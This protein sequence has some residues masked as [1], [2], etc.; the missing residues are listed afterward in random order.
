MKDISLK[1]LLEAGCHF[2][3]K[4]SRWHPKASVFIYQA[5]EGIHIIDLAKTRDGL[6]NAAQ[7]VKNL[8]EEGKVL[9]M[10][11]TKRQ[12]KA[13]VTEAAKNKGINYLTAR[14]IGGF[15]TNWEEVKKNIDKVN[16][17]RKEKEDG[18]WKKF[19]KHEQIA[20]EKTLKKLESVYTGVADLV[21]TPDAIFMVDIKN[22]INCLREA[23]RKNIPVIAI[24]D[25]NADPGKADLAIPANDDAVGS[26]K[27]I[28]EYIAEAYA[29]GKEIRKK[30]EGQTGI[31]NQESGVKNKE[32]EK[33]EAEI[34]K[35]PEVKEEVKKPAAAKASADDGEKK[36]EEKK[37]EKKTEKKPVQKPKV[38]KEKAK[39]K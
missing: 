27:I 6:K 17:M 29:E 4:V 19:V 5:R 7:Y 1:D 24:V 36:T 28:S 22:E 15:L 39:K 12:A 10:V 25:T 18:S 20:L 35:K 21:A 38:K 37:P 33:K 34:E 16:R 2:G 9:L 23:A 8:G 11:A 13:L 30:A 14:Y 32:D 26:I 31:K 3:H